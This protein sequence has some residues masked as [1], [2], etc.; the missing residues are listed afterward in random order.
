MSK[1]NVL[2][3]D[4]ESPTGLLQK[5]RHFDD[6]VSARP[7]SADKLVDA[8]AALTE[9][10]KLMRKPASKRVKEPPPS[11]FDDLDIL[12]VDYDLIGIRQAGVLTGEEVAYLVRCYSTCKVVVA[13]NQFFR[14]P[15]FDLTLRGH[16][17]SYA[18]VN[19]CADDLANRWLWEA[20]KTSYRPWYWPHL[21]TLVG[22][23]SV[24]AGQIAA[25]TD[26]VFGLLRLPRSVADIMSVDVLSPVWDG[27]RPLTADEFIR[28]HG[29]RGADRLYLP[30]RELIVASRLGK[31]VRTLL[32]PG[33]D[34]IV[35]APHLVERCPSLLTSKP[36][37][38]AYNGTI[39]P[40]VSAL[41][42]RYRLLES[43]RVASDWTTVPTWNWNALEK[44]K[45]VQ[46]KVPELVEPWKRKT[47]PYAFCEDSSLFRPRG[48]TRSF[49]AD[50]RSGYN[51][52]AVSR[53]SGVHYRPELRLAM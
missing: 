23:M 8:V 41:G 50:L 9:R 51:R 10:Q 44:D 49:V 40:S 32:L 7:L 13:I 14:V 16:F 19:I 37:L 25:G 43:H 24:R 20:A 45:E 29:L 6:F 5:I 17:D 38:T 39:G 34:T 4:D 31:W 30:A 15:T 42:I 36:T 11:I 35:D 22:Q 47:V 18:D 1:L 46:E 53:V 21:R 2:V 52:R 28:A 12:V 33:Q 3:C 27:E 48:E 26:D